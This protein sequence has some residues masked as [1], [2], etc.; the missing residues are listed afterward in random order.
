[1]ATR[2]ELRAGA[3]ARVAEEKA[4]KRA[5]RTELKAMS[6]EERRTAKAADRTAARAAKKQAK[7]DRKAAGASMTRAERRAMKRRE[8]TYRRVKNR[9]RRLIGWGIAAV[10]VVGIVAL[11]APYAAGIGRVTSI[12][13]TD[14]TAAAAAARDAAVPVAE[15]VS[16]EGIVLLENGGGVLPLAGGAVNVF[17]FAS[18]NLRLGGGGSGGAAGEGA[19]TLYEA[20]EAQGV[21][22]NH[23]LY[24]AM[25]DAGAKH[26]TGSSNAF[27][28]IAGAL[29]GGDEGEPAPDYLTDDVMAQAA[30]FSDTALV[31]FGN[32]G[33]EGSD[34][35]AETLRLS[36]AQT[37]LL[38][39]VTASIPNVV[40]IINS[41]NQMELG[42]LEEYPEIKAAVWMGTPGPQGAVSLA[43]VLTGEVNPSG[44]LTDTYAY[45][46]ETA[47][48]TENLGN[49]SYENVG[50][51][52]LD[53]EEGIYVG[54]RYYE[55][56]YEDD[57]AY[58]EIVQYPFGYGLSYTTFEQDPAQP[59]IGDEEISVDVTVTNTGDVAGKEVVQ[60]YFSAPYIDGGIEK[61]AIELA[62]Y[63]KTSLLEPGASETLTVAFATRDMSSWSTE[64]GAYVLEGGAYRIAVSSDVHSPLVTF[65]TEI[66][67]DVVYDTDEVTGAALESRFDY[68]ESDLTYLSRDDWGN[69]YPTAP[70]DDTVASEGLLALMDPEVVPASGDAPTYGADNGLMLE[71]LKGLD[72]DDPRWDDFLDQLTLDEQ[73]DLFSYG[74]YLTASVDR[75][76]IP[77]ITMLDSPAG[78]NS[79]FSPLD[80]AFYPSEIVIASTW[81]DELAYAV[82]ESV[83]TEATAYGIDVWYAPGMNL[84]RTAMGGRDFE[85]F[86]EDPLLSGTMGAAMVAGAEQN[87]VPTTMKHFVLNDQEV[88]ARSG[89]N[90]FASEQALRELYLRPFEITVKQAQVSGAMSSFINIGGVWAGGDEQ[91]LQEVLRGEWGFEGFVTTDAVLGGWMDPVQAAL[92]GNDLMLSALNPSG[93]A[94]AIKS[95]AEDD[96]A[97]VGSALRDRVQAVLLTVLQ[98]NSFD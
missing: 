46:V 16:D 73:A 96:P 6:P 5:R 95:A 40:V 2:K 76:G 52:F 78:L 1:M 53:Y 47:P 98:T 39:T 93:T 72:A 83:A 29:L 59:V 25:E 92:G 71:D 43:K 28:Q 20:L 9:P 60:V 51:A 8:R 35:T 38:D 44:R 74:A 36:A 81:N 23:D 32:S 94:S 12:T 48:A 19:P 15:A 31:V 61:S 87:G 70:G 97:G 26:E 89:I 82:G 58:D 41:G 49:H 62:G 79:L 50:R 88:N 27:V 14:D 84:H 68:V 17:S 91:L 21:D 69:T 24:A 33:S 66:A 3:R 30:D 11:I 75:L 67:E 22:Y 10:A 77:S 13:F 18:F 42:F 86:S 4:A 85:Y 37:A 65:E 55:T 45:D 57:E 34:F 56:R 64:A 54:Y 63:A 7:A 80:S 90:V